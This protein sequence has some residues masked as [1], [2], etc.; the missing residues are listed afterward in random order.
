MLSTPRIGLALA[1]V[2]GFGLVPTARV[3]AAPIAVPL[4]PA[5]TTVIVDRAAWCW[6]EG[7]RVAFS[8]D[9]SRLYASGVADGGQASV[10]AGT[11]VLAELDTAT[12][13]RRLV[14]LGAGAKDDHNSAGILPLASGE[15]ITSWSLHSVER[16]V[17]L[18]RRRTDGSW[19]LLPPEFTPSPI[20]RASYSNLF[21]TPGSSDT[22]ITY[23]FYRG[24]R[25]DPN[26]LASTDDG[27]SWSYLGRLLRDPADDPLQRPY[28]VYTPGHDGRIEILATQGHPREALTSIYHGYIQ[29]NTVHASD[30]TE[31]GAVGSAIAVTALTPVYTATVGAPAWVSDV[32]VDPASGDVIATFSVRISTTD[33]RY[34]YARYS[35]SSWSVDEI[36]HAGNALFPQENDYT[37]LIAI[38]ATNGSRVVI[39]T[40]VDPE[41]GAPLTSVTDG[42]QHWELFQGDLGPGGFVWTPLTANSTAD[43]IR[44]VFAAGPNQARAL[45]WMRG[46]YPSFS[47]FSTDLVGVVMA[48]D[49]ASVIAQPSVAVEPITVLPASAPVNAPAVGIGGDF[50]SHGADD[51]YLYRAGSGAE[52]LVLGDDRQVLTPI[53]TRAVN[54]TYTPIP[55][56]FNGDSRDDIYWYAPGTGTESLWLTNPNGT[57]TNTTTRAV[58]GTY[59]PIPGDFN[60][61]SRDDIRW[62]APGAS[63]DFTSWAVADPSATAPQAV[64]NL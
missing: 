52:Q 24:D 20:Q 61:D 1:L 25:W 45:V 51:V 28:V 35:G 14:P 39:S 27:R 22:T 31:L 59:T 23:D 17:H 48:P 44:P 41:T 47:S 46:R 37:G 12:G 8:P 49:G 13:A 33:H 56:D 36:A 10:P 7:P 18:Q 42:Q 63:P 62:Y 5:G 60:G 34:V 29:G 4:E 57:F 9:G 26:V 2:L 11:I 55:G 58:N 30:G 15:V 3:A 6:F 40:D 38:D 54:G 53:A 16:A 19:L 32:S 64:P 43:N 21:Q 50:D